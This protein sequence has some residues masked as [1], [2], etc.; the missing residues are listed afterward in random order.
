MIC[1][2]KEDLKYERTFQILSI[3]GIAMNWLH[4]ETKCKRQQ[5]VGYSIFD[6]VMYV[7]FTVL[8]CEDKCCMAEKMEGRTLIM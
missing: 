4:I 8:S 7:V 5:T 3:G 1:L 2:L 6:S